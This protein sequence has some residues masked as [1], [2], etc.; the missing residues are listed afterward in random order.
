MP[1]PTRTGLIG[2]HKSD[3]KPVLSTEFGNQGVLSNVDPL[4]WRITA[5]RSSSA[6]RSTCTQVPAASG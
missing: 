6:R 3:G 4:K 1:S 5:A 2:K